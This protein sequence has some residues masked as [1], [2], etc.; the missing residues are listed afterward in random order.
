[1]SPCAGAELDSVPEEMPM[2]L[3]EDDEGN[4]E[5]IIRLLDPPTL[6][7]PPRPQ[8]TVSL[9]FPWTS[10][11]L[12]VTPIQV[13]PSSPPSRKK[14][15]GGGW[16]KGKS[17]KSGVAPP[18]KPPSSGYG[19]FLSE[20]MAGQKIKSSG[21]MSQVSKQ[22]GRLWSALSQPDKEVYNDRS[23]TERTRYLSELKRYLLTTS[24]LTGEHVDRMLSQTLAIESNDSLLLCELCKL[25][26]T[27]LHNKRCHYSGRLH[28]AALLDT[29]Q[30]PVR[31]DNT[32]TMASRVSAE[33]LKCSGVCVC[34]CVCVCVSYVVSLHT[35]VSTQTKEA[36][37][38]YASLLQSNACLA[39]TLSEQEVN[40]KCN[41]SVIMYPLY[42]VCVQ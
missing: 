10:L 38:G 26:F 35:V 23:A 3:L 25:T 17:R 40:M 8:P 2:Y 29:L 34:V 21:S 12:N 39:Q 41:F 14:R 31:D 33:A 32:E 15:H 37:R 18:P 9:V 13:I 5:E 16:P 19:L 27:S 4:D 36:M 28:T 7:P 22:L 11:G 42:I 30:P 20:H 6:P 1:M 24:G